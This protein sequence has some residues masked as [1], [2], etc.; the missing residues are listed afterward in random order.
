MSILRRRLNSFCELLGYRSGFLRHM[1]LIFPF[2]TKKSNDMK[3]SSLRFQ[4]DQLPSSVSH[5]NPQSGGFRDLAWHYTS[6][7]LW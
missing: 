1:R 2:C 4:Q 5:L 7:A 3:F 6:L